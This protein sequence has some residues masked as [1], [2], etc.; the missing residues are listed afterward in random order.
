[1]NVTT[2]PLD[3]GKTA[4]TVEVSVEESAPYI[5]R[6]ATRLASKHQIP[7]FR[8]GKAPIDVLKSKFGADALYEEAIQ[9]LVPKTLYQA[10]KDNKIE[11][12]G[13]PEINIEKLAPENPIIYTATVAVMPTV[14]LKDWKKVTI[15][16]EAVKIKDDELDTRIDEIREMQAT[17]KLVKRAAKKGD[18]V[19]VNFEV[20]RNGVTIEGGIGTKYPIVIGKGSMIP[21]FE[22]HIIGVKAGEKTK[23][24][25]KFPKPY[26]QESLAGKEADFT[27]DVLTVSERTLPEKNDEWAQKVLGKP[28]EELK[29]TLKENLVIE[30]EGKE[31]HR[32]EHEMMKKIIE[33]GTF[34]EIPDP[35]LVAEAKKMVAELQHDVQQRGM[36]WEKYLESIKKTKEELEKEFQSQAV[37]RVKGALALRALA[38][39]LKIEVSDSDLEKEIDSQL[40]QY[41]NSEEAQKQ[42]KSPEYR[43]YLE[44]ILLNR[45]T[46]D[47]LISLLIK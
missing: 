37:K 5:E 22:D 6:A 38:E 11:S 14:D 4:V 46:I 26:M 18:K 43:D 42:L 29:N 41:A 16:K 44:R 31:R 15:K 27:I 19:E 10:L 40:K 24:K 30:K 32:Q 3:G 1:M 12:V 33:Q 23:F 7:G 17:E 20:K 47:N 36:Q 45:K 2:K 21:G 35:M 25:L 13:Q 28:F 39:E 34:S 8:P 9:E